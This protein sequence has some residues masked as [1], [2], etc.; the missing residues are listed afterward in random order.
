MY[1][2][3]NSDQVARTTDVSQL[4]QR[5]WVHQSMFLPF[6]SDQ[7]ALQRFV[8][9]TSG[10][11]FI[12]P[13][14]YLLK[15]IRSHYKG[16]SAKLAVLGSS[17]HVLTSY[18]WSG[19]TAEVSQLSQRSWVHQSTYLRLNGDQAALQRS[20]SQTSG[21]GSISPCTYLLS[22]IRSHCRGQSAKP[23]VLGP[24]VH[25]LTS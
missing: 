20:V 19:R 3:L 25:V 6:I 24:S 14:T 1:L 9:Q 21:P 5:S 23:A 2:P 4:N 13:R 10:P 22:V 7:V 16:L 8:S 15:V 11:G 18:Q 12:S 17:V